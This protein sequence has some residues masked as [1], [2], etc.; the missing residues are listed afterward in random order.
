MPW[1]FCNCT[2]K[3]HEKQPPSALNQ[4]LRKSALRCSASRSTVRGS[5]SDQT[6]QSTPQERGRYM[7]V[8]QKETFLVQVL[9]SGEQRWTVTRHYD[10]GISGQHHFGNHWI[11]KAPATFFGLR[12]S[13]SWFP[14]KEQLKVAAWGWANAGMSQFCI[15]HGICRICEY[16]R[17]WCWG[18][19]LGH[20]TRFEG[21]GFYTLRNWW[22]CSVQWKILF[23]QESW[24]QAVE[25]EEF[26]KCDHWHRDFFHRNL[27][28]KHAFHLK[29]RHVTMYLKI[30]G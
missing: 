22:L 8:V 19:H 29:F 1:C 23:A 27:G 9:W 14:E 3:T 21:T 15:L 10:L 30:E 26:R 12:V 28:Q 24:P 18:R 7:R 11:T 16:L 25:E 6:F 4:A 2:W 20:H 5:S 13:I 17:C